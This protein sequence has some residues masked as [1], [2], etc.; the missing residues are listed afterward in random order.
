MSKRKLAGGKGLATACGG[1]ALIAPIL[2]AGWGLL[3]FVGF[4]G[5]KL[6]RGVGS[7]IP[8]NVAATTLLPIPAYLMYGALGLVGTV[9]FALIILPKHVEQMREL[10]SPDA[11]SDPTSN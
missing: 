6:L 2:I 10:L 9:A 3:F 7:I 5:Y 8:G 4:F 1:L 11:G